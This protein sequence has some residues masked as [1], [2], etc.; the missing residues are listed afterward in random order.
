VHEQKTGPKPHLI[1][2]HVGDIVEQQERHHPAA[3]PKKKLGG[4][5]SD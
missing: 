2:K 4:N 1:S 3:D 5:A